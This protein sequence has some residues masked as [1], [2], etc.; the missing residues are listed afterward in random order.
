MA[1]ESFE[2]YAAGSLSH[3]RKK[4]YYV[5]FDSRAAPT[6]DGPARK[7]SFSY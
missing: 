3:W 7:T 6:L 1:S 5:D 4:H 2:Y